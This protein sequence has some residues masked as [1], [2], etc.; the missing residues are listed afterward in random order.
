MHVRRQIREAIKAILVNHTVAGKNV[1]TGRAH[2]LTEAEI[3]GILITAAAQGGERS[4]VSSIGA[5]N[6]LDR[7]VPIVVIGHDE[8]RE[9]E[10][11]LDAI[12]VD[13]ERLLGLARE[14]GASPLML[15]AEDI[16]LVRTEISIFGE[17][18]ERAGEI[19]L[20]FEVLY[21]TARAAPETPLS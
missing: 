11:R 13:V 10:D 8:G 9:V 18:A 1:F 6:T 5:S 21:R 3:P 7:T 17:A 4:E 12:A 2:A 20:F 14:D 19:R 15:V 16:D